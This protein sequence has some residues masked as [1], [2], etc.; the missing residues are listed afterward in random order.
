MC[1]S[2][3]GIVKQMGNWEMQGR[4]HWGV[5]GGLQPLCIPFSGNIPSSGSYNM[6]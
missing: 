5:A 6:V 2:K 1:S 4:H 3:Q